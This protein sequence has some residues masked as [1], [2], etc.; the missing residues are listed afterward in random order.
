MHSAL[1]NNIVKRIWEFLQSRGFWI[2]SSHFPGVENTIADKMFGV[3]SDNT[4]WI[5]SR[6]HSIGFK[7]CSPIL[8]ITPF[9]SLQV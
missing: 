1:F 7:Q 2:S 4:E 8:W 3:F 6:K 5:L 9:S